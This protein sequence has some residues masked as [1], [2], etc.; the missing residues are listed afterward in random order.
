MTTENITVDPRDVEID[1]DNPMWEIVK[2]FPN[3]D[4]LAFGRPVFS[5]AS[6]P[7]IL[8]SMAA[9]EAGKGEAYI[10]GLYKKFD[11]AMDRSK[12]VRVYTW[13]IPDP[14]SVA[15][16][17]KALNGRPMVEIGAGTGYWGWLMQQH[18]IDVKLYDKNPP[19][20]GYNHW[21]SPRENI[22]HEYTDQ[23]RREHQQDHD[24]MFGAFKALRDLDHDEDMVPLPPVPDYR[25]LPKGEVTNRLNGVPG[26][27]YVRIHK[28]GPGQLHRPDNAERVLMLSWPPYDND[29][30]R[31]V[32]R[33]YRGD[34][35]VYMGEMDGGC[36]GSDAMF[37]LLEKE[38]ELFD[39]LPGHVQW[40]GIHDELLVY[41]RRG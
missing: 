36:C 16:V 14:L 40:S 31:D 28:G 18:G 39:E 11:D 21:H 30:G 29:F 34:T 2:E 6:H 35:I 32:V 24:K 23:E 20:K 41:K 10:Q 7:V 19:R 3:D 37:S 25:P 13:S 38:W 22:Y 4:I 5:P 1:Y 27:E 12:L 9:R 17:V 15:F 8:E 26:E 33:S